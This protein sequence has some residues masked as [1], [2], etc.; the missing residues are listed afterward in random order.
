MSNESDSLM[1]KGLAPRSIVNVGFLCSGGEFSS[2]KPG[3]DARNRSHSMNERLNAFYHQT[4]QAGL[5]LLI[6]DLVL[7]I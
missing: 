7:I 5:I 4:S 3:D 1:A 2:L 6:I